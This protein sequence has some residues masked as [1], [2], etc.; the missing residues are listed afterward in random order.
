MNEISLIAICH[1]S[2]DQLPTTLDRKYF[3]QWNINMYPKKLFFFHF[4]S[5]IDQWEKKR[6]QKESICFPF[7]LNNK[8]F[9]RQLFLLGFWCQNLNFVS[10]WIL[11]IASIQ[12]RSKLY[13]VIILIAANCNQTEP[14]V[15]AVMLWPKNAKSQ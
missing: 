15:S 6:I 10:Y 13:F 14:R 4:L 3:C 1:Y 5:F 9:Y 11:I 2:T 8:R 7:F 12:R